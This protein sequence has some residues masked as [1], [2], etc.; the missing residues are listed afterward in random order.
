MAGSPGISLRAFLCVVSMVG[1]GVDAVVVVLRHRF[2][3]LSTSAKLCAFSAIIHTPFVL[4]PE[5]S[6]L[7][8]H[9]RLKSLRVSSQLR[10]AAELLFRAIGLVLSASLDLRFHCVCVV[11]VMGFGRGC[12][13]GGAGQ[14]H[15]DFVNTWRGVLCIG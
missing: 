3:S 10:W 13:D 8:W 2:R 11:E 9:S 1:F 4:L 5:R 6:R 12:A 7:A 14:C 15:L